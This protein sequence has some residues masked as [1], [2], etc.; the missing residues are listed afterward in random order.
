MKKFFAIVLSLALLLPLVSLA[1]VDIAALTDEQLTDL[2]SKIAEE[3][4]S[5]AKESGE[6]LLSGTYDNATIGLKDILVQQSGSDK[7][8]ILAFDYSHD[9]DE[10]ESFLLAA[11]IKVFQDG[12]EL[13]SAYFYDH[14]SVGNTTK[15]IKKGAVLEVTKAYELSSSSPIEIEIN[16][17][18]NLSGRKPGTLTIDLP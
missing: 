1:T 9:S 14:P 13:D 18:F 8:L 15:S 5:R 17:L 10:S 2:A 16:E 7:V 4:L 11:S 3:Q 12:V 6:Y